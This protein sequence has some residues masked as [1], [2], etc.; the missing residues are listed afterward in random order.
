MSGAQQNRKAEGNMNSKNNGGRIFVS[1]SLA[2]FLT[3]CGSPNYEPSQF[4]VTAEEVASRAPAD[5]RNIPRLVKQSP[6]LPS[7]HNRAGS[8]TFD[9]VVTNVPARG[10]CFLRWRATRAS[11][12]TLIRALAAWF[13][14][15]RSTQTLDAHFGPHRRANL[16]ARRASRRCHHRQARRGV[17]QVLRDQLRQ[18]LAHREFRRERFRRRRL[19]RRL[20]FDQATRWRTNF[21]DS[22]DA[23]LGAILNIQLAGDAEAL[24]D[25]SSRRR[26]PRGDFVAGARGRV[27]Q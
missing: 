16:D 1:S 21:W 24:N 18:H 10:I 7:L 11:T 20:G 8:E 3:A 9:V 14:F 6:T 2:V 15:P 23:S 5:T 12:W 26:R 22:L 27:A 17:F 13:R 19:R 4:H 25:Y